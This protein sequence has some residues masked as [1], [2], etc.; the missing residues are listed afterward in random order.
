MLT[1]NDFVARWLAHRAAA[2]DLD[3]SSLSVREVR[4]MSRGVSRQTWSVSVAD[5]SG[6]HALMVR[7]DHEVGSVIPTSLETEYAVYAALAGTDVP[8]ARA[9]WW[10]DDPSW[11]P[12]GRPAYLRE[13]VTGDWRLPELAQAPAEV[14]DRRIALAREHI[15]QL[16]KVHA[17]DWRARGLDRILRAPDTP[18]RAAE[19]LVDDLLDQL[20][21]YQGAPSVPAAEAVASLR[22]RAPRDLDALVFCKGTNGHGEEVWRDGRIVAMSDWELAAIGDPAYDFAQC[23]ELV[24]DVVV[25]GRRVWGMPEALEFYRDLTGSTVTMDR[26]DY[27][28]DVM[29][30]LQHVYTQHAAWVVRRHEVPPLR[31]VWTATEVAFRSELRLAADYTGNLLTELVA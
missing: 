28:R 9:L 23:Q 19:M 10:E 22:A 30:L 17:V 7:R 5:R 4:P 12:D 20:R 1:D 26:V 3:A 25:D 8:H 14:A 27:Y 29:A 24:A 15:T 18:A 16:A 2:L 11:M 31:F 13:C 6:E 21:R